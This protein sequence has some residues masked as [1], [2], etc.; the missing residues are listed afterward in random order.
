ML[1]NFPGSQKCWTSALAQVYDNKA[2]YNQQ[3]QIPARMVGMVEWFKC[4]KLV[5]SFKGNTMKKLQTCQK[6]QL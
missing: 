3:V 2:A 5:L 6:K 1:K 4:T